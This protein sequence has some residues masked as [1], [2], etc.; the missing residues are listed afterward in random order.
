MDEYNPSD[1]PEVGMERFQRQE[2]AKRRHAKQLLVHLVSVSKKM[3]GQS[4]V[5]GEFH[6]QLNRT[7]ALA[8]QR[9][10]AKTLDQEFAK[11]SKKF[12]EVLQTEGKLVKA[13]E[14]DIEFQKQMLGRIAKLEV[15]HAE[16]NSKMN[17]VTQQRIDKLTFLVNALQDRLSHMVEERKQHDSRVVDL[18]DKIKKKLD[19]KRMYIAELGGEIKGL[20]DKYTALK[21]KGISPEA[22]KKFK[23]RIFALRKQA[24]ALKSAK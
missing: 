5:Q 17:N 22:L 12:E 1:Y 20:N 19:Q 24:S 18:E 15:V 13:H 3:A 23:D 9:A 10:D 16:I 4:Q 6:D 14:Q 21:N 11:L 8:F 2:E 7:K